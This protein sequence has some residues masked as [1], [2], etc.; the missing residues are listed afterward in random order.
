[1]VAKRKPKSSAPG[2]LSKETEEQLRRLVKSGF[3]LWAGGK[4]KGA[5]P[6]I[7]LT[8]GPDVSDYINEDRR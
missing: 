4:P 3:M 1:M 6:L 8:P 7:E 2:T 5:D